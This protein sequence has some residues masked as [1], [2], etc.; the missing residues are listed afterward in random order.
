MKK[1]FLFYVFLIMAFALISA[2]TC[3]CNDHKGNIRN[4][5]KTSYAEW[6][7]YLAPAFDDGLKIS[8]YSEENGNIYMEVE[9]SDHKSSTDGF[10]ELI[11]LHDKFVE[12][13]PN[14]FSGKHIGIDYRYGGR[15]R[16]GF[17][18]SIYEDDAHPF[19]PYFEGDRKSLELDEEGKLKYVWVVQGS[20]DYLTNYKDKRFLA[21]VGLLYV[22]AGGTNIYNMDSAEKW[23]FLE[24]FPRLEKVVL[25]TSWE[26]NSDDVYYKAIEEAKPG[27]EI[28]T[29]VNGEK[30]YLWRSAEL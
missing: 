28:I 14:Y 6:F 7:D 27:L 9:S 4:K 11:T 3:G 20:I 18:S 29:A 12:D 19:L 15:T 22:S 10:P 13:N 21:E 24:D 1:N 8:E 25:R 2:F 30:L 17:R 23:A 16:F 5:L 26:Y